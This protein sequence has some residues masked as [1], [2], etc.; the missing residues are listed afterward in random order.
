LA[1]LR[2]TGP[3]DTVLM[4]MF[5]LSERNL[6]RE[7]TEASKRG[8]EIRL[9]LDPNK[10]A[11]GLEKNGI[12]NRPVAAE[13]VKKSGE[14]IKVRWYDTHGEQYHTKMI[15]IKRKDSSIIFGGSANMTKRNIADLNLETDLKITAPNDSS[16]VRE[17]SAYFDR[18]WNNKDGHYTLDYDAYR[19]ES[20]FRKAVYRFQEWS[21]LCS[22]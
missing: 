4:G 7:L 11:F 1:A 3:G 15:M 10:D 2:D 5:Y 17:I 13:L 16:L 20:V 19:D 21:G 14:A 12:P 18:I 8:V 9:V 6:V 22:F